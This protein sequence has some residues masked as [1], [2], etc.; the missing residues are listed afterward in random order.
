[1]QKRDTLM[2]ATQEEKMKII[3]ERFGSF[4]FLFFLLF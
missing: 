1:M 4:I 3:A 2:L